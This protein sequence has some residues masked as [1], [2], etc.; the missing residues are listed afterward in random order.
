M[1]SS[2]FFKLFPP[3][4]FMLM[5]HSGLHISDHTIRFIE[6][7]GSG[8]SMRISR[9]G[10]LDLPPGTI[11]GGEAR[12]EKALSAALAEFDKKNDLSYVKVSVPEEKAYLFQIEVPSTDVRTIAQNIEFK[13]EE[14]VPL[15]ASDAVFYFDLL[16]LE[17]GSPIRASVSVVSRAYIEKMMGILRGCGMSPVAFEVLPKAVARSV[18]HPHSTITTMIVYIMKKKTGIYIVMGNVV[19]FSSTIPYGTDTPPVDGADTASM[20]SKEIGRV[21][22]FWASHAPSSSEVKEVILVGAKAS[23]YR[24]PI[25]DPFAS[26]GVSVS[27]GDVWS[28]AFDINKY[29]PPIAQ[30]DSLDYVVAA[31]LAMDA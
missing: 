10:S 3:P 18:I 12:D 25:R 17:P 24:E 22:A 7:S 2:V 5:R 21:R 4:K 31:G 11:E 6:Y 20:I 14:N 23:E 9:F 26:E 15:T 16:P 1:H 28:N 8:R 13:L 19:G 30:A 29:I 27:V